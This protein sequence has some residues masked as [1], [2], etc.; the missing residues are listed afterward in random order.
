MLNK[1]FKYLFAFV[2]TTASCFGSTTYITGIEEEKDSMR[3]DTILTGSAGSFNGYTEPSAAI[4]TLRVTFVR[5]SDAGSSISPTAFSRFPSTIK[6]IY[7][8]GNTS[9]LGTLIGNG[10]KYA[11]PTPGD[12]TTIHFSLSAVPSD[13]N[14][15]WF[16]HQPGKNVR[17]IIEPNS[18]NPYALNTS[19]LNEIISD[20]EEQDIV[21]PPLPVIAP[22]ENQ[23][24]TCSSFCLL[25]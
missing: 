6:D 12:N 15:C 16:T 21:S 9:D 10:A 14:L 24:S 20:Q 4:S 17:K 3:C 5:V 2:A 1:S 19:L 11:L 8:F 25:L 22:A 13:S 18:V 7:F 23:N